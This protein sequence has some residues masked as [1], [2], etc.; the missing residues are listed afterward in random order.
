MGRIGLEKL[1]AK[2]AEQYGVEAKVLTIVGDAAL[3]YHGVIRECDV[4]VF[5]VPFT[6]LTAISVKSG[7]QATTVVTSGY[8]K[9]H[10]LVTPTHKLIATD[11]LPSY[12]VTEECFPFN[13]ET[14]STIIMNLLKYGIDEKRE[15]LEKAFEHGGYL[16]LEAWSGD[17]T[18]IQ[19][20]YREYPEYFEIIEDPEA[21][22]VMWKT[23]AGIE[24][25]KDDHIFLE[26]V[27]MM[28]VETN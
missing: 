18:S 15:V 28:Y 26:Y 7:I 1:I 19:D 14:L 22:Q 17:L 8:G 24:V 11:R 13:V 25:A 27:G 23:L 4:P 12:H 10:T 2:L 6:L 21:P 3:V 9:V 5:L 20:H 16:L